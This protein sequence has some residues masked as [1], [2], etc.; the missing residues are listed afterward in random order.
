MVPRPARTAETHRS[1]YESERVGD[2]L[3]ELRLGRQLTISKLAEL[4]GVPGS[5]ISKIENGQLRPS[6][7]NA[8]S[9]ASALEENLGFLVDRY[10][11]R[12]EPRVVMRAGARDTIDYPDM[13]LMLQDMNGQFEPGVLESRIGILAP[14][15]HSGVDAMTHG[16]DEFCC[17]IAGAIRYRIAD[18]IVDLAA[19]EYLQFKSSIRHSWENAHPGETRVLWVFSDELSF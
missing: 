10:R 7:V 15:A 11:S 19:G 8:I 5:T 9:L 17:V 3:R 18:R 16:G 1:R 6:L 13:G 2:R 14:G 12:P 4:S